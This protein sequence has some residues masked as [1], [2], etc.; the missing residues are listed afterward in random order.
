MSVDRSCRSAWKT[1]FGP[2]SPGGAASLQSWLNENAGGGIPPVERH[3]APSQ[4]PGARHST[5]ELQ[6]HGVDEPEAVALAIA[7]SLEPASEPQDVPSE[8]SEGEAEEGD[9]SGEEERGEPARLRG[10][11]FSV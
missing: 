6:G 7:R 11:V 9:E 5:S 4:I 1:G 10:E 8:P 3:A 2:P